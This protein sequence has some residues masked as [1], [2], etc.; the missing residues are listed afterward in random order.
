[1]AGSKGKAI[2]YR[3]RPITFDF[4]V[5]RKDAKGQRERKGLKRAMC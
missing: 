2:C 4:K 3:I 5:H 1:M